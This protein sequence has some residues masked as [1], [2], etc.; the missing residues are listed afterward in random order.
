MNKFEVRNYFDYLYTK[1]LDLRTD[2]IMNSCRSMDLFI[3]DQFKNDP[4]NYIGE[5][6]LSTKLFTSYNILMYPLPGMF[7]LYHEIKKAYRQF[8]QNDEPAY[9]QSWLNVYNQGDKIDWHGHWEPQF[10]GW[11]GF[12]CVNVEPGSYTEYKIPLTEETINIDS[13]NNLLV[14]GKSDGDLHRSSPWH[15][16]RIPRVT[17]AFDILPARHIDPLKDINHWI[18]L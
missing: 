9:V 14:L 7:E 6:P 17:I 12:Y 10:N 16:S 15:D 11:H 1:K 8:V 13:Y 2:L 5:A 3:R 4:Q 18:P